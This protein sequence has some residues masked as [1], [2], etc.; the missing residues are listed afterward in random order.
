TLSNETRML[1]FDGGDTHGLFTETISKP[2]A[3]AANYEAR[4][5]REVAK[6]YADLGEIK[7]AHRTLDSPFI[8]PETGQKVAFTRAN[9]ATVISNMG[10]NYNWRVLAKGWGV[11]PDVLWKWVEQNSTVEDIE[12]AQKLGNIFKG[13]KASADQVYQHLYGIAPENVIP[14]PFTMH[15]KQFEGWYHPVIG[16]RHLSRF[17]NKMPQVDEPEVNFW[18][19]TSNAYMK[20]RTG[21]NQV[22]D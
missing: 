12:R 20:R 7:D 18:P 17:V 14:R 9:L 4:L 5:E 15:G 10:N 13:L 19:S 1:R 21:A 22:I 11:D 2:A 8:N 3:E 16:D 6:K